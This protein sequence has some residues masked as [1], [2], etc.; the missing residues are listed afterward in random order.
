V[1]L[2]WEQAAD[3]KDRGRAVYLP[4]GAGSGTCAPE[5]EGE[6]LS[7]DQPSDEYWDNQEIWHC[8]SSCRSIDTTVVDIR[9][10]VDRYNSAGDFFGQLNRP[11][12]LALS[13]GEPRSH[14]ASTS[15]PSA[16][17]SRPLSPASLGKSR[18][19]PR[20]VGTWSRG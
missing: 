2:E 11:P 14:S 12:R 17:Y 13:P 3:R 4:T 9:C 18:G 1:R 15:D 19:Q 6:G 8:E 10:L 7:P 20:A 16:C 5:V